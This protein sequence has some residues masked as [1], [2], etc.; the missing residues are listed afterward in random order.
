MKPE[1]AIDPEGK[2]YHR[3]R[4]S[5]T[6]ASTAAAVSDST[7]TAGKG[8]CGRERVSKRKPMPKQ[9]DYSTLGAYGA[10]MRAWR[11]EADSDQDTAAQKKALG[12]M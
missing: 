10:A 11:A 8:L 3:A 2:A 6:E 9:S 4:T 7:T 1:V 5:G 12:G